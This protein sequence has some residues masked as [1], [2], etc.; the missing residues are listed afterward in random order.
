MKAILVQL[1]YHIGNFEENI[2][3][4]GHEVKKAEE[5][6]ADLVIFSELSLRKWTRSD[7]TYDYCT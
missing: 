6:G 3:R 4:V 7:L 2:A 1:N 5:A